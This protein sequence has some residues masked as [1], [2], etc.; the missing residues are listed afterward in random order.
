M[1]AGAVLAPVEKS[2]SHTE[3]G[4]TRCAGT[5]MSGDAAE[6]LEGTG[7]ELVGTPGRLVAR[8][9]PR[10]RRQAVR[11]A[12]AAGRARQVARVELLVPERLN[13]LAR[14]SMALLL[15][16][17]AAFGALEWAAWLAH[18]TSGLPGAGGTG[19]RVAELVVGNVLLYL[20]VLPVHEA[21]HA[22]VILGLGGRPRFGLKLP[23]ALYCTAPGQLFTRTGYTAVALSPLVV[24]S[25]AGGVAIWLS[26]WLGAYLLLA[27]VGN[28]SGAVGDLAAAAGMRGLPAGALIADTATGYTAY[29]VGGT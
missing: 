24:L 27:L 17:A 10:G 26:P 2:V 8:L 28:V 21:I 4:V 19:A 7:P 20:V 12:L 22:G 3:R 25:L 16:G 9:V 13:D 18:E 1:Y 15:V 5:M 6:G 29:V 23:L 14:W 11:A